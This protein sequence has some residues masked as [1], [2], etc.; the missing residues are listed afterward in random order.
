MAL[1]DEGATT[2]CYARSEKHWVTDPQGVAWEHFHTLGNIP[3]VPR[4]RTGRGTRLLRTGHRRPPPSPTRQ[5]LLLKGPTM[6]LY[7]V[8]FLCT[9]N[10]ARSIM[11]E[12]ILNQIGGGRF[13]GHSAGSHPAG[14]VNP[15]ALELLERNRYRTEG[16]R[17]KNWDEFARPD[18][19]PM[20][21]VSSPC[22]TRPPARSAPSGLASPCRPTG[23][24]PTRGGQGRRTGQAAAFADA[25]MTLSRRVALL[26]N[27]PIDKL[28]KLALQNELRMR[29][30]QAKGFEP[31]THGTV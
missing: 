4:G 26:V 29:L 6:S 31:R 16:L 9:G 7:N 8:L 20:N 24:Y 27:L 18:A 1:L 12:A 14:R 2:C 30:G 3:G 11:A 21:F 19:P 23:A 15:H 5:P 13:R 25:F 10:S 28:D 17:S 22:A